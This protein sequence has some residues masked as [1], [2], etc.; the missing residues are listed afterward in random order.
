MSIF[1]PLALV[2]SLLVLIYGFMNPAVADPRME[3]RDG[4]CHFQ[5]DPNDQNVEVFAAVCLHDIFPYKDIN[6]NNQT[7][8]D[9]IWVKEYVKGRTRIGNVNRLL[10]RRAA[11]EPPPRRCRNEWVIPNGDPVPPAQD[12]LCKV[13]LTGERTGDLCVLVDSNGTEYQTEFWTGE[14]F[15]TADGV[16]KYTLT[17]RNAEQNN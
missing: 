17:C 11:G 10:A 4:F 9:A 14:Y 3:T 12:L 5:I 2:T 13:R 6:G 16:V 8:G 1:K 7:D 15:L